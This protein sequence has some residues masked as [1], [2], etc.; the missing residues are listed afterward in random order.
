VTSPGSVGDGY[1]SQM[2]AVYGRGLPPGQDVDV[3]MQAVD[4]DAPSF[5]EWLI[6][7][8]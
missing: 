7:S 4:V 3:L 6:V 2:A 8:A 5:A 1:T